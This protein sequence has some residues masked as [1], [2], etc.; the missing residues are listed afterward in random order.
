MLGP[1]G[2]ERIENDFYPTPPRYFDCFAHFIAMHDLVV[3]E[4]ACGEGH[5]SKRMRELGARVYSTDLINR[6]FGTAPVDFLAATTAPRG[7]TAIITNTPYGDMAEPFVRAALEHT[8]AV[9]GK[10]AMFLRTDWDTSSK[11]R[12]DLFEGHPAY[13][14]KL[15]VTERPR[16]FA[17]KKGDKSPRFS[18][19]WY[20]WDWSK[21]TDAFPTI[22]YIHPR[23]ARPLRAPSA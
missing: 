23:D 13:C 21:P 4:P 11:D 10:V 1:S 3:W 22:R 20:F 5:L 8:K 7:V 2:Y 6:G 19:A 17:K 9:G 16:W 18:F 12:P 15:I 14:M